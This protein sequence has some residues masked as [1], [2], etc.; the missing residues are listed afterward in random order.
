MAVKTIPACVGYYDQG[1]AACDGDPR[2]TTDDE[3]RACDWCP[4][5][6]AFKI[7]LE[8]EGKVQ[9]DYLQILEEPVFDDE[10]NPVI[11]GGTGEPMLR[12]VGR[13]RDGGKAF[14]KF[15]MGLAREQESRDLP[16]VQPTKKQRKRRERTSATGERGELRRR[17][18]R[19]PYIGAARKREH[20][21]ER[22]EA[23]FEELIERIGPGRRK[24]DRVA[25][26]VGQCYILVTDAASHVSYRLLTL[27]CRTGKG[28]DQPILRLRPRQE[29]TFDV[30]FPV[31]SKALGVAF[32]PRG[33][34]KL[35]APES[36][37]LGSYLS[38]IKGVD[39]NGMRAVLNAVGFLVKRQKIKLPVLRGAE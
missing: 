30:H 38:R 3:R 18:R 20:M 16:L 24:N 27:Y 34:P 14:Y 37:K 13:A 17:I 33:S 4:A 25:P 23:I 39:E 36:I 10:G 5:C 28:R 15:C 11:D 29:R 8:D 22:G 9:S 7:H 31:S 2:G 1:H 6:P 21:L 26:A 32:G 19:G 35:E 12:E